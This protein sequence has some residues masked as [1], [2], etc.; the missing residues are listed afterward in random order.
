MHDFA[1]KILK[2]FRGLYPRT[3]MAGGGDPLP[4]PT[5]S[6]AF[7]RVRGR[8]AP[9]AARSQSAARTTGI[10]APQP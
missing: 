3:P 8:F 6:M 2:I 5:P 9:A 10:F 7:G 1:C 4:A